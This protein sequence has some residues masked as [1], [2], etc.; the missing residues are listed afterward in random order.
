MKIVTQYSLDICVYYTI[1][2]EKN[3]AVFLAESFAIY[4]F[5]GIRGFPYVQ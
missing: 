5:F 1:Q 2:N 3:S 4:P